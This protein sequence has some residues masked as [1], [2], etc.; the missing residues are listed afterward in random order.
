MS[1]FEAGI[2]RD[3]N[4]IWLHIRSNAGKDGFLFKATSGDAAT[5]IDDRHVTKDNL[6]RCLKNLSK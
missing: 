3:I 5:T 1:C 4:S 2:E 6:G